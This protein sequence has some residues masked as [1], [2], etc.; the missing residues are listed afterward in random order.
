MFLKELISQGWQALMRNRMRSA[1]TML[2][3]VWGLASVVILLAYGQGLGGSVLHAF[4]NMGNSVIVLWPG[5]TSMQAGGQRAGKKV[6]YE[7]EDVEAV[8]DEVPLVR[9][10][11][12]ESCSDFGYKIGT[13]VV[14]IQTRGVELPYGQMRKLDLE[15]GRY[16]SEGDFVDHRRVV[17]LG[18]NAAK[19]AFQGAPAVS[20]SLTIGG[21]SF[22]VI[23]VLRNKIQ[24]SMYQGPD[25][26]DG[27]IPFQ[28]FRE[29]KQVR[30][31]DMIIIQPQAPELNKKAVAAVRAVIARR[32][33]F[34]PKDDKATPVWDTIESEA[35]V[36]AFSIGL[37][38]V[39]GLIGAVTLAVGGVGVM[40]IMLVSVTERTREIGLRKALGARPR[41]ILIQFLLEALVLT[42]VGG[43]IGMGVAI[44]LTWVI[45]PMPLYGD[46]YK[47]T[48]HEGDIFLHAS[49]TV[50]MVSFA[51]LSLVGI[52]SGFFPALKAARMDPV[53]ALHYE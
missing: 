51:I 18:Y 29:L 9:A 47:T 16:F 52:V 17:I 10:V 5:Q 27:F 34:D 3:I 24:D 11:S 35:M 23:G 41:H 26:E 21:Q 33:H 48:N 30:D 1:L 31:P 25:N 28:V 22:E 4:L 19:K 20:Q 50:M 44:F 43:V 53:E 39:L 32:H 46:L 37:Q 6:N 13:R 42:F 15:N 7:Y 14:S 8:R 2:G 40:N 12:A 49:A 36:S 45:P 38:A